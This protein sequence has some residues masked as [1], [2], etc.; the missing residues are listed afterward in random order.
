MHA[1][2]RRCYTH[3][4]VA[5]CLLI[6]EFVS[7]LRRS[8]VLV[9]WL[10]RRTPQS[11]HMRNG[12]AENCQ[13]VGLACQSATRWDHV[14]QL[15][16]VCWHFVTPPAFNFTM[17]LPNIVNSTQQPLNITHIITTRTP[18]DYELTD[19]RSTESI[20]ITAKARKYV[21]TGVGLCVCVC[22]CLSVTMITKKIVDGFVPNF[23]GRF[24]REREDQVRVSLRS[25]EGC[26]SSAQNTP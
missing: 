14:T 20:I 9:L 18:I 5:L 17:T 24:Q 8:S 4:T 7:I 13:L 22:V 15:V 19:N 11:L 6:C 1:W 12:H 2:I 10:V 16:H 23:M 26:G 25:V 21:F 3:I